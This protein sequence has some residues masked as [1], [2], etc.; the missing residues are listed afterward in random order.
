MIE[1][2]HRNYVLIRVIILWWI[3]KLKIFYNLLNNCSIA[4]YGTSINSS[5]LFIENSVGYL[6]CLIEPSNLNEALIAKYTWI[7]NNQPLQLTSLISNQ[8]DFKN[9][10]TQDNGSYICEIHLVNGQ[11]LTS[12]PYDLKVYS[13]NKSR[14]YN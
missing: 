10:S 12:T 3:F 9:I 2:N 7:K 4:K 13:C 5:E 11:I 1:Y 8:I 14:M 6:K